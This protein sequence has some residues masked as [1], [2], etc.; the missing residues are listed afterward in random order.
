MIVTDNFYR[1]NEKWIVMFLLLLSYSLFFYKVGDRDIWAPNEDELVQVN[2]EMVLD[3]H[4]IYPTANGRPYNI[5]PPLFNWM[6]SAFAALN[7]GVT[8]HTSRLPSAIAAGGGLLILYFF[9]RRL[10]GHRAALLSALIIGTSPLYV[11]FG[12]WIQL[13][14]ISTVLLMATLGLFY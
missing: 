2:R 1:R 14:M 3:G 9:G 7:G 12:R 13:N 10:F 4:W 11:K 8:E 5:K 6:G